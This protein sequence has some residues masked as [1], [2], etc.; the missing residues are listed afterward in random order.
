M[1]VSPQRNPISMT[2]MSGFQQKAP[3]P[4]QRLGEQQFEHHF[5]GQTHF[6]YAS[7]LNQQQQQLAQTYPKQPQIN[8]VGQQQFAEQQTSTPY[9]V[10]QSNFIIKTDTKDNILVDN[11]NF[12]DEELQGGGMGLKNLRMIQGQ[13]QQQLA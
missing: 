3:I 8:T 11:Q 13:Q 12:V 7:Q 6:G 1:G 9:F 5:N 10:K 4:D 2:Q